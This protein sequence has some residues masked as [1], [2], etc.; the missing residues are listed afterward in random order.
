[1][2]MIKQRSRKTAALTA[3]AAVAGGVLLSLSGA[4][5]ANAERVDMASDYGY[6]NPDTGAFNILGGYDK[7][8]DM[9][10]DTDIAFCIEMGVYFPSSTNEVVKQVETDEYPEIAYIINKWGGD[11]DAKNQ[12]AVQY[13]VH[14]NLDVHDDGFSS[15]HGIGSGDTS[16]SNAEY[17]E[18]RQAMLDGVDAEVKELA[19]EYWSEATSNVGPYTAANPVITPD[20]PKASTGLISGFALSTAA[21]SAVTE[22]TVTVS[23]SGDA[24]FEDGSQ[25]KVI[26]LDEVGEGLRYQMTKHGGTFEVSYE[27]TDLPSAKLVIAQLAPHDG[28]DGYDGTGVYPEG[29]PYAGD[30]KTD[31]EGAPVQTSIAAVTSEAGAVSEAATYANEISVADLQTMALD[32]ADGDK[33]LSQTGGVVTD[34]VEYHNLIPGQ[35]YTL[36]AELMDK[37]TGESTGFTAQAKFTP[38]SADG[39]T[40]VTFEPL[41]ASYAG[42]SLVVFETA[43]DADGNVVGEH[44]D[45]ESEEQTI[46]IVDIGTTATDEAD[47]DKRVAHDGVISDEVA[48]ENLVPGK[49]YTLK[50]WLMDQETGDPVIDAKTGE[51]VPGETVFTPEEADGTVVVSFDLGSVPDTTTVAFEELY[52]ADGNLIAEHKDI[53]DRGQTVVTE[54]VPPTEPS[55]PS[56]PEESEESEPSEEPV[57]SAQPEEPTTPVN[58]GAVVHTG[59]STQDENPGALAL[60]S[61][62]AALLVGGGA[63]TYRIRNKRATLV[64]D[65]SGEG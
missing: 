10:G 1:M 40:S 18:A 51:Q 35:E 47:G 48:Y 45:L 14:A 64:S 25:E 43:T 61:L 32:Q 22:D 3:T 57:T 54:G 26:S 21:G 37:E 44:K 49:E 52:D 29:S 4:A 23:L 27:A 16:K 36:D 34:E 50:G 20:S 41:D 53:D 28:G 38:E 12:A 30:T 55:E 5:A 60:G 7:P 2:T 59:G 31:R 6:V 24:T 19:D 9:K 46:D 17:Q 15:A 58:P 33:S 56:E 11:L 39:T 42:K 62:G 8:A 65:G 13:L 63:V